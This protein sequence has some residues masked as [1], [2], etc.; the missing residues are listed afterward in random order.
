MIYELS[1]DL[2]D[3]QTLRLLG[4]AVPCTSKLGLSRGFRSEGESALWSF[5]PK[6]PKLT[7]Q[8]A[9]PVFL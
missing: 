6:T 5:G 7:L 1:Q 2:G 4:E 8:Q 9:F 3:F